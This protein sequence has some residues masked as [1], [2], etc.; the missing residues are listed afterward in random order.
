MLPNLPHKC[1]FIVVEWAEDE[2]H[3]HLGSLKFSQRKV[4]WVLQLLPLTTS[5]EIWSSASVT[6]DLEQLQQWPKNGD[7]SELLPW[8]Q[9]TSN[10]GSQ[11][12]LMTAQACNAMAMTLVLSLFRQPL[13]LK[14]PSRASL[15]VTVACPLWQKGSNVQTMRHHGC[16]MS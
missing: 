13:H 7:M 11:H 6:I 15:K 14:K 5:L 1:D 10:A 16:S 3:H 9:T 4:E 2:T 12:L 8:I